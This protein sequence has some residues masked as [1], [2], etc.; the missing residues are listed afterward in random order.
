MEYWFPGFPENTIA[1]EHSA[2]IHTKSRAMLSSLISE[3]SQ[4]EPGEF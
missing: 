2:A 4:K 1:W 3:I